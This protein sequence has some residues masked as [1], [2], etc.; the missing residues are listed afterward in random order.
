MDRHLTRRALPLGGLRFSARTHF[1]SRERKSGSGLRSADHQGVEPGGS[2]A[3]PLVFF[4]FRWYFAR[5]SFSF[6][7]SRPLF[8]LSLFLFVSRARR[9]VSLEAISAIIRFECHG[10][11]FP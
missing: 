10:G 3:D 11:L 7:L 5:G 2:N 1:S 9:P 4:A 8:L 6:A